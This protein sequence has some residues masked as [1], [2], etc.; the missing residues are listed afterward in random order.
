MLRQRGGGN[1]N[2]NTNVN[3]I[4]G[5][6]PIINILLLNIDHPGP[7][8]MNIL[9]YDAYWYRGYDY[10]R[11]GTPKPDYVHAHTHMCGP[12]TGTPLHAWTCGRPAGGLQA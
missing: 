12:K 7:V 11:Q 2:K 1:R 4:T 8:R 9:L 3:T 5:I 6:H 10:A